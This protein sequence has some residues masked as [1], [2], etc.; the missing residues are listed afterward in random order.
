[1]RL[2]DVA[3]GLGGVGIVLSITGMG[4]PPHLSTPTFTCEQPAAT[5]IAP[6]PSAT[7][8]AT[9]GNTATPT[10]SPSPTPS[11]QQSSTALSASPPIPDLCLGITPLSST[12]QRTLFTVQVWADNWPHGKV[13]VLL[14]SQGQAAEFTAGCPTKSKKDSAS[15]TLPTLSSTP[16]K[17]QAQLPVTPTTR[18]VTLTA[19]AQ[20]TAI[21]LPHP[22]VFTDALKL[23]PEKTTPTPTPTP[24]SLPPIPLPVLPTAAA[25]SSVI[26]PGN[27]AGLFPAITASP[28]PSATP[29]PTPA[30]A[31]RPTPRVTEPPKADPPGLLPLGSTLLTAQALGLLALIA[32]IVLAVTRYRRT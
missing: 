14:S 27:A 4:S 26:S 7:P 32:A 2:R 30:A 25:S 8:S 31:T 23:A 9:A 5:E 17:L 19:T 29:D 15:C 6:T 28:T 3:A 20:T 21:T 18:T 11:P 13:A 10:A 12:P 16:V 1:M 22:L 24:V